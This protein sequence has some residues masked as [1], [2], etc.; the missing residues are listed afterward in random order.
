[1]LRALLSLAPCAFTLLVCADPARAEDKIEPFKA[2][3][4]GSYAANQKLEGVTIGVQPFDTAELCRT[5]FGKLN[6]NQHEVLPVLV[7]IENNRKSAL[8][9]DGVKIEY[10][11]PGVGKIEN[12]T[13]DELRGVVGPTRPAP[14]PN[15][16]PIPRRN[17]VK[18]NPL[19]TPEVEKN[20]WSAR[21][22]A[23][24]ETASGFFYFQTRHRTSARIYLT[25][26]VEPATGKELFYYEIPFSQ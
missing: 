23:P 19:L 4:A 11:I 21:M 20:A 15:P 12:T 2:G 5:A 6:P 14:G 7:V 17:K 26:L 22:I 8:R 1:M 24:G 16:L 10:V 25:A 9:V 13:L 3:A 18:K